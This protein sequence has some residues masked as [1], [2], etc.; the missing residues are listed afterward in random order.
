MKIV[1]LDVETTISNNGNPFDKNNKLVMVGI[2]DVGGNSL[3]WTPTEEYQE[4]ET[5][6]KA[7]LES[8]DIIVGFNIKFDIH[9]IRNVFKDIKLNRIW[10][11]QLAEFLF[12][13]QSHKYPS[14]DDSLTKYGFPLKLDIVKN[15]Y[16]EKG[17]DT[18]EVP[19]NI[20]KEYLE[21]DLISTERLFKQQ[22]QMFKSAEYKGM[23]NLFRIQCQDLL[24][25]EEME[26]NGIQFD[27]EGAL[28]YANEISKEQEEIVRRIHTH[29]NGYN[30]NITSDSHLSAFL[31][32]G[33]IVEE[34]RIPVGIYK[35]GAKA[36][37]LR[38]NIGYKVFEFPRLVEPIANSAVREKISKKELEFV[39]KGILQEPRTWWAVN[40]D[41]LNK[42][43]AKKAIK[44]L[45]NSIIRYNKLDKLR[46]S[47][48]EGWSK[49]IDKMNWPKNELHGQFNQCLVITGR[50]SSNSPNLQNAD[51][52]TK[53]YCKSRYD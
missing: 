9:W 48:L 8:A 3:I 11:C 15:E 13:N 7:D 50:L 52:A 4:I 31:Y 53:C 43:K 33:Q 40:E 47:Y 12:S 22:Y 17:I 49:L 28:A 35:T 45:I 6:I 14:L 34:D 21:Q 44:E 36:G 38:Y 25:L 41:T 16:W 37:Q 23:Y 24:V 1:I 29:T 19:A 18:T 42:L 2:K 32:G 39:D 26:Y 30:I 10:D 5:Y 51:K 27:S 46:S 20:L